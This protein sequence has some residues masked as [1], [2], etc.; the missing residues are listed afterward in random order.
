[1]DALT[2]AFIGISGSGKGTQRELLAQFLSEKDSERPVIQ[3]EMSALLR[4]LYASKTP[5]ARVAES[6]VN[7]GGLLPTFVPTYAFVRYC[8]EHFWGHE[9]LLLDGVT[10]RSAQSRN[11]DDIMRFYDRKNL[12]V[13]VTELSEETA[14][15]RI[16][17]RQRGDDTEETMRKRFE[18]YRKDVIPAIDCLKEMGWKV[19]HVDGEADIQTIHHE[20]LT[21]LNINVSR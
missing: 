11:L 9:H 21:K 16:E 3:V 4:E 8:D 1:M 13:V 5:I 19:H 6:I 18:W 20:I 10:R 15:T 14:L 17:H 12:Q 2:V 7:T